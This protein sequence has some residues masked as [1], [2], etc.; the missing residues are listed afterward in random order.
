MS[1]DEDDDYMLKTPEPGLAN[2]NSKAAVQL[3]PLDYNP[4]QKRDM[5]ISGVQQ[6]KGRVIPDLDQLHKP[7][8]APIQRP[9]KRK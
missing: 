7:Q 5:N 1:Y 6:S 9:A 8:L 3:K 4:I 2:K